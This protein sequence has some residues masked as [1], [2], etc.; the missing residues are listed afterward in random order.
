MKRC[1]LLLFFYDNIIKRTGRYKVV[2]VRKIVDVKLRM[3]LMLGTERV[4]MK[5]GWGDQCVR[6][7]D[8][9][10]QRL[11]LYIT[12]KVPILSSMDTI[13]IMVKFCLGL[14][15]KLCKVINIIIHL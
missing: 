13:V 12:Y 4:T 3:N 1:I 14:V 7:L 11:P 9:G 6:L 8:N 10:R 5:D 2:N 15:T